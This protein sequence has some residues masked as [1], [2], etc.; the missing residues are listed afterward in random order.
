MC[1]STIATSA[2]GWMRVRRKLISSKSICPRAPESRSS[3]SPSA[4]LEVLAF[5]LRYAA[6]RGQLAMKSQ[7]FGAQHL[8][9]VENLAV[10]HAEVFNHL[11]DRIEAAHRVSLD[12]IGGA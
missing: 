5:W 9:N 11:V 12:V 6:R 2:A 7:I 8:V 1:S 4:C 3:N 10:V